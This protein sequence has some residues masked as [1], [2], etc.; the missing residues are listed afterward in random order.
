MEIYPSL[1]AADLLNL[2]GVIETLD[3]HCHGYHIDIMDG[4]FVPNITWGP[5]VSNAIAAK[6]TKPLH[7][8]LMVTNPE[9]VIPNLSCRPQDVIIF[10]YEATKTSSTIN[11]VLAMIKQ[12]NC[13]VGIAINPDTPASV[14][15]S[16]IGRIDLVLL[17][18]VWPGA[19]GQP[20]IEKV[21][22]KIPELITFKTKLKAQIT[23]SMDGGIG[24]ENITNLVSKGVD[25]VGIASALFSQ[26]DPVAALKKL[27]HQTETPKIT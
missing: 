5:M 6:T 11:N 15:T 10:H 13:K 4:H 7:I 14:L 20:F 1:I 19:S 3:P 25:N 27:Y 12:K 18:S 24:P 23:L 16:T 17:M 21:T 9:A 8:H 26:P 22:D 2:A